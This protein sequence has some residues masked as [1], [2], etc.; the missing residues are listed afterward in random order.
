M[1]CVLTV[2]VTE[3]NR[4]AGLVPVPWCPWTNY[5]FLKPQFHTCSW[6]DNSAI[7]FEAAARPGRDVCLKQV[8]SKLHSSSVLICADLTPRVNLPLSRGQDQ[9]WMKLEISVLR[10]GGGPVQSQAPDTFLCG[11]RFG[12]SPR[13]QSCQVSWDS[14]ETCGPVALWTSQKCPILGPFTPVVG[15]RQGPKAQRNPLRPQPESNYRSSRAH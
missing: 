5:H 15:S 4:V 9:G 7:F 1:E 12:Q 14:R 3:S 2:Q 13:Q 11:L 6:G 8:A 10:Q